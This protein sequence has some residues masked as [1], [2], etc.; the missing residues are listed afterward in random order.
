MAAMQVRFSFDDDRMKKHGY[1]RQNVYYT[2]KKNFQ[3]R[4]LNCV[5]EDED[6]VFE[7]TGKEDDYGNMWAVILGL[8]KSDWFE[9]CASSC[10]FV[11]DDEMED[12]LAQL[13][14]L[15]HMMATA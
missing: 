6:L 9:K 13:P 8:V 12:V 3:L 2:I 11:E 4:G 1:Q 15:K 7:D 14:K 5:S 10:V